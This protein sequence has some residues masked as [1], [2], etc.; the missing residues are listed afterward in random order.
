[1]YIRIY[2]YKQI[3]TC[4]NTRTKV[5]M[6]TNIEIKIM[7]V[8]VPW[9]ARPGGQK[10]LKATPPLHI[11]VYICKYIYMYVYIYTYHVR[12]GQF[13]NLI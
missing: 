10:T 1:M 2:M 12:N 13:I 7:C 3:F 9:W 5:D 6:K 4:I 8:Y 11:Y